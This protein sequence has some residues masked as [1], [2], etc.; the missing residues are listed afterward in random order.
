MY[1]I[2]PARSD[3][4]EEFRNAPFG[5]HSP[6]MQKVLQLL[7]WGPVA[8]RPVVVCT[9]PNREWVIG[10]LPERRGEA[11]ALERE[12]PF[13]NLASALVAVFERRWERVVEAGAAS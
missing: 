4:I 1:R 13:Q 8:G 10:V 5:P 6:E 2:D 7:R 3:L 11:I 12:R 9:V